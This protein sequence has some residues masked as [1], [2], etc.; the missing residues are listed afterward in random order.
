MTTQ[1][2][3]MDLWLLE[4]VDESHFLIRDCGTGSSSW[5]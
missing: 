1:M 2:C 5:S 3:K 4:I